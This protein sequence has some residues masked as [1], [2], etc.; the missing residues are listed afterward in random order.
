MTG[1][2]ETLAL[3]D[4]PAGLAV[5]AKSTGWT[6]GGPT[7]EVINISIHSLWASVKAGTSSHSSGCSAI[8]TACRRNRSCNCLFTTDM[9][10]R[11][12]RCSSAPL[13]S[14]ADGGEVSITMHVNS[15]YACV[16]AI[17]PPSNYV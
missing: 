10:T 4:S 1:V 11:G 17:A 3:L 12:N 13:L 2:R 16:Q 9:N 8:R 6:W 7:L 14:L 5:G 15:Y